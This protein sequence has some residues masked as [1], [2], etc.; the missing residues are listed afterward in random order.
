MIKLLLEHGA[1][2]NLA[3][4]NKTTPVMLAAGLNWQDISNL[5]TE[6]ESIEA[7]QLCLDHGADINAA[8]TT[9]ETAVHGAA[10]RGAN[11]VLKF[12]LSRGAKLD[13]KTKAGRTA[14]D[15]ALGQDIVLDDSDVRRPVRESTV[16]L[17][18][19]LMN[20][21]QIKP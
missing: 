4:D 13:V 11:S 3:N 5:G 8:N 1:D 20:E 15:E 6:E 9:G 16:A 2:P 10:E 14:L 18:R 12:L 19:Q 21:N 17:L 7:I